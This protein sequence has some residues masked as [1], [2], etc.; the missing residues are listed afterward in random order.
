MSDYSVKHGIPTANAE[1]SVEPRMAAEAPSITGELLPLDHAAQAVTDGARAVGPPVV[2]AG[3]VAKR[4]GLTQRQDAFCRLFIQTGVAVDAYEAAY[5]TEGGNRA[6]ARVN[7]YRLLKNP[8]VQQRIR[9]LQDAA[10]DRSLRSTTALIQELQEAV[11]AD[12][13]ELVRLDVGCCRHCHGI[14]GKYQFKDGDEWALAFA[15]ALDSKGV[16]PVPSDAGGYG[17]DPHREV[18]PSCGE[19]LGAGVPRVIFSSTADVSRGA[20]RL[21]RGV[22]LHADGSVKRLLLHDQSALRIE[23]HKLRGLHVDRSISIAAS[24]NVPPPKDWT[25]EDALQFLESIR[26]TTNTT[27]TTVIDHDHQS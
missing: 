14:G 8:K 5:D 25:T 10:A 2:V 15:T 24:V 12:I 21:L 4:D 18:N 13:N 7:A 9:E 22:E 23:L 11:D 17:F 6:T 3:T 20:R 27:P 19:C 16:I 26:P 1:S